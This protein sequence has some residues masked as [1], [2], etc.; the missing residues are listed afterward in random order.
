MTDAP[1]YVFVFE[2]RSDAAILAHVGS[3]EPIPSYELETLEHAGMI[4]RTGSAEFPGHVGDVWAVARKGAELP[5]DYEYVPRRDLPVKFGQGYFDR[6]TVAYQVM[7]IRLEHQFCG[8]CG[9]RMEEHEHDRAMICP[10]CGSAAY[11]AASPAV[12]VAVTKGDK[13]LL[14][15]NARFRNGMYSV[16]AGFIEPGESAEDTIRREIWEEARVR[17]KNIRY[18]TSQMWPFPNSLM[19]AYKAE[20]ESGD[21][22]PGDGELDDVRWFSRDEVPRI[23]GGISV[24]RKLIDDWLNDK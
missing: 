24:S 11:H 5:A 16:L 6:C 18:F 20:W 22:E 17:V 13:L 15:H 4:E 9:A 14:G 19:L 2:N 23:P 7:N 21:P 12:I 8:V 10:E 1:R 3:D